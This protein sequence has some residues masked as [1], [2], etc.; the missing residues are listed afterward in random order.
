[1]E[2]L[3]NGHLS[4]ADGHMRASTPWHG[5]RSMNYDPRDRSSD[6]NR[7]AGWVMVETCIGYVAEKNGRRVRLAR[8]G[9]SQKK[10]LER[11]REFVDGEEGCC[12]AE[13]AE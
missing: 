6:A 7:R 13:G 9:T 12:G 11:F 4:F 3:H 8:F 10:A 1:M 2:S 5:A